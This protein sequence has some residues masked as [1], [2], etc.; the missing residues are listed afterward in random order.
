[1]TAWEKGVKYAAMGFAIFLAVAI[2]GSIV[3]AV[4]FILGLSGIDGVEDEITVYQVSETVT[5]LELEVK[6]ASVEIKVGESFSV[7]SNLKHLRVKVKDGCLL[8]EETESFGAIYHGAKLVLYV[9]ADAVLERAEISTGAGRLTVEKITAEK[10]ELDLGAG[11]VILERVK[12]TKSCEI[13]GGAGAVTVKDSAFRDLTMD[14]GV[15]QL[16]MTAVLTGDCD[17]DM[18]VGETRLTLQGDKESYRVKINKGVGSAKVDGSYASDGETFG[19]GENR[20]TINGGVG[21]VDV[22]FE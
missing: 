2:I 9:P 13:D 4:G 7:E 11:E 21:A 17:M 6:A 18:G 10:L 5:A 3:T 14:M 16:V 19:D 1:M 22:E 15:G 8:V 12:A 20:V